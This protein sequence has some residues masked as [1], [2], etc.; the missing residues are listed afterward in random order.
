MFNWSQCFPEILVSLL[1]SA[2]IARTETQA[3]VLGLGGVAA[4]GGALYVVVRRVGSNDYGA[5]TATNVDDARPS[6]GRPCC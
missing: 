5:G 2:V 3:S 4:F 1:S 6:V